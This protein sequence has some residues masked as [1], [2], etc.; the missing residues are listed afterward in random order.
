MM[1]RRVTG[2]PQNKQVQIGPLINKPLDISHY[3]LDQC[4]P[5]TLHAHLLRWPLP[6]MTCFL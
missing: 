4:W 3:P 2:L 1:D 5:L 6:G